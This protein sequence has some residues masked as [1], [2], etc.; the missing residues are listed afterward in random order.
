MS[1]EVIYP[2]DKMTIKRQA[3]GR[4]LCRIGGNRAIV[5]SGTEEKLV[6][7][8]LGKGI[9]RAITS[10]R[11][12]RWTCHDGGSQITCYP[13]LRRL[14]PPAKGIHCSDTRQA[15][16]PLHTSPIIDLCHPFA[17]RQVESNRRLYRR[18]CRAETR[19][20]SMSWMDWG[21]TR[22]I[23]KEERWLETGE[24]SLN[25]PTRS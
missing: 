18:Q 13:Q 12:R 22:Q 2:N 23:A 11:H 17:C 14:S 15:I 16:T 7:G 3:L 5:P 4:V 9:K 24:T 25:M 6:T 21:T 1:R 10:E 20:T 8:S 19:S